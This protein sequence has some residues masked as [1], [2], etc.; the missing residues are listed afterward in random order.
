MHSVLRRDFWPGLYVIITAVNSVF[1]NWGIRFNYCCY[2]GRRLR[3]K[4][5]SARLVIRESL[6][7]IDSFLLLPGM[8]LSSVVP[9]LDSPTFANHE[10]VRVLP[11]GIF[12]DAMVNFFDICFICTARQA[13]NFQHNLVYIERKLLSLQLLMLY[14]SRSVYVILLY[15]VNKLKFSF[16]LSILTENYWR[17]C[18]YISSKHNIF[19][20]FCLKIITI[21]FT[22]D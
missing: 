7:K 11:N 2:M 17:R 8:N 14:I 3:G 19:V 4:G 18:K 21:L 12:N 10:L 9:S 13:S 20:V 6:V 15:K 16:K 1:I 22:R 5:A